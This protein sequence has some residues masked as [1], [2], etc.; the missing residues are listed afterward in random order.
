[1]EVLSHS[2]DKE[3]LDDISRWLKFHVYDDWT[4]IR[5]YLVLIFLEHKIWHFSSVQ[6]IID[7]LKESFLKYLT[8]SHCKGDFSSIDTCFKHAFFDELIEVLLSV[9]FY[10]LNLFV[11][12]FVHMRSHSGQRLLA[13]TAN[14]N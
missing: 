11:F 10:Y 13:R 4:H 3:L 5:L 14:T 2:F 1:M 7:V 12:H 9:T 8:I 6:D